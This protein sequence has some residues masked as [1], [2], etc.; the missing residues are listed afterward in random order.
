MVK[1]KQAYKY[2]FYKQDFQGTKLGSIF[3]SIG[4]TSVKRSFPYSNAPRNKFHDNG[5][6]YTDITLINEI[7]YSSDDDPKV[8]IGPLMQ[9]GVFEYVEP[10]YLF[11]PLYKPNDPE[12]DSL[13]FM[14]MLNMYDAWD[15][16][17]GDTNVVIGISDTGFD[18]DHPDL[19]NSVK[20]NYADPIDG[21][22]NDADGYIDNFRGWDL[23]DN[24]NDPQVGGNWHGIYVA[25]FV[26]ATADN[27]IQLAG[28]GFNCKIVPLK[29]SDAS[30]ALTGAY[31]SIVYAANHNFDVVNCSWGS[32]NSWSQLG[33]DICKYAT[34]DKNCLVVA[35]AGNDD[36][37]NIWYPASYDWVLSVG[38]TNRDSEKW[39]ENS[40]DGSTY[41]DYV[42]VVAPAN[43]LYRINNGGGSI[44]GGGFGTSFSAPIVSGIAGLIKSQNPSFSAPEL[45]EQIKATARNIDTIPFNTSYA[46]KLGKGLVDANAA[47]SDYTNPGFVFDEATF[48]DKDDECYLPG[49]TVYLQGLVINFLSNSSSSSI[50]RVE[51]T[52]PHIQ[53]IDSVQTI[54]VIEKLYSLNTSTLP[55]TFVVKE[56]MPLNEKIYFKVFME[57]GDY[58]NWKMVSA[59]FNTDYINLSENNIE[60][61][62]GASGK[63]GYNGSQG[64]Q[65]V[66]LGVKYKDA[67]SSA[68]LIGVMASLDA[69]KT[70][71][72]VQGG[73]ES[74][75]GINFLTDRE[76]DRTIYTNYDDD[77]M[78]G[79]K[80]G[81]EVSQ[82]TMAWD[83]AD[84]K[85]FIIMEMSIKNTSGSDINDMSFGVYADWDIDAS[86]SSSNNA[87]YDSTMRTGYV[88][89]PGGVHAG[90]HILSDSAFQHYAADNNGAGGSINLYDGAFTVAEQRATMTGG[91]ARASA[92]LGDVSQTVGVRGL[93]I[94]A[95][96]SIKVAFALVM[97]DDLATITSASAEAD[98]AY[99]ELNTLKVDIV[100]LSNA[101]CY[102]ICDGGVTLS[103]EGGIGV[104][105]Y[106]WYDVAGNPT[107]NLVTSL[108]AS[109]YHCEVS[110]EEG[111]KDTIEVVVGSPDAISFDLGN[112]SAFCEGGE[113]EVNE[114]VFVSYVWSPG[115]ETSPII[116][117]NSTG[118]YSVTVTDSNGC[119]ANDS[120]QI[121]IYAKPNLNL[122]NDISICEGDSNVVF[123]AGL[124]DSYVWN[125]SHTSQTI[126]TDSAGDYS[127]V[128][129]DENG[130]TNSDTISLIVNPSPSISITDTIMSD[131]ASCNGEINGVVFGGAPA[132][133][134][135]WSDDAFRDSIHAV[136]LCSDTYTVTVTDA[137]ACFTNKS[138]EIQDKPVFIKTA[139]LSQLVL[140][141]N[142][143]EGIITM[144]G[145]PNNYNLRITNILG[146]EVRGVIDNYGK[147]DL[148]ELDMGH[149]FIQITSG[150]EIKTQ[151]IILKK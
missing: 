105:N 95:G 13:Y 119:E 106:N 128:I 12:I 84:R 103:A 59:T 72:S 9:T 79:N 18:T 134:I 127:V 46:G 137:N 15:V 126:Q 133:V 132:Y 25:S 147:L 96:D 7:R 26:G 97:G 140:F 6:A 10:S 73:F 98:T 111:L 1:I 27:G 112:D 49:D 77:P 22:D 28:T 145:L 65:S 48:T 55:L 39:I 129:T 54:G 124:S 17:K 40:S 5:I 143:T 148:S 21:V 63:I 149:Y 89:Y 44:L 151:K 75:S 23:G 139:S 38:G 88:N 61:S 20:Y 2:Q 130:C 116:E 100:S 94:S 69:S 29:I 86:T 32:P 85:D 93:N 82:K 120:I 101:S 131:I 109:T 35:A 90:I 108:C 36:S 80:I 104:L 142:P 64:D 60:L 115:G 33:Q 50:I 125:T 11:Q 47:L 30:G 83:D 121:T 14:E 135:S 87:T 81:I 8:L 117:P 24:D 31:N 4:M 118:I 58:F 78:G 53:L 57:D 62:V 114:G 19:V 123:D 51:T 16:T 110:D 66:G 70:I 74:T 52:S 41:N 102:S 144:R 68:Y 138:I 150:S 71:Y 141:P 45:L 34:V 37:E 99:K 56:T 146:I 92:G 3:N 42:D 67:A 76:A 43:Q 91:N 136:N 122:G 113:L 107:S